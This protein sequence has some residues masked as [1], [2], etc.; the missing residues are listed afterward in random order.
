MDQNYVETMPVSQITKLQ[1]KI[2]ISRHENHSGWSS[3][4]VRKP[5]ETLAQFVVSRVLGGS[6]DVGN[7]HLR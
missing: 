2:D 1:R 7:G 3:V 6:V 4:S 5:S